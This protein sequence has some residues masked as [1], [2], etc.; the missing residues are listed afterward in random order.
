MWKKRNILIGLTL[1]LVGLAGIARGESPTTAPTTR[2]LTPS[3]E[4]ELSN[5]VKQLVD[6]TRDSK[7][8]AEA[9]DLLLTRPYPQ[10]V[11]AVKTLLQDTGNPS[12]QIAIAEGIVR[13]RGRNEYVEPLLEMLAGA[14]MAV[15]SPAGRALATYKDPTVMRKLIALAMDSGRDRSM[16]LP[17]IIALKRVLDKEVVDALMKLLDD[18]DAA[19]RDTAM[20]SLEY[21]TNLRGFH[22]PSQWKAWWEPLKNRDRHDWLA[23]LAE[24]VSRTKTALETENQKLGE[25]LRQSFTETYNGMASLPARDAFTAKLL[26]EPLVEARLTGLVLV[27]R[28]L[29]AA[30]GEPLS[31]DMGSQVRSLLA[32]TDASVREEAA[33]TMGGIGDTGSVQALMDRLKLEDSVAVQAALLSALGQLRD[34]KVLPEVLPRIASRYDAVSTAAAKALRRIAMKQPLAENPRQ[35]AVRA[36]VGRYQQA[37][38]ASASDTLVVREALLGAM[39]VL[40][41][42]QFLPAFQ[43]ACKDGN[44]NIRQMGATA[45]VELKDPTAVESL[46]PLLSDSDRNVRLAAVTGTA[47][48]GGETHLVSVLQRVDPAVEPEPSVREAAWNASLGIFPQC[49]DR[50]LVGVC[51]RLKERDDATVPYAQVL[52]VLV[53]RLKE[54]KSP[55][56]APRQRELALAFAVLRQPVEAA[57]QLAD[58]LKNPAVTGETASAVWVE[59]VEYLLAAEDLSVCRVLSEQKNEAD[60][61]RGI[62]KLLAHLVQGT[63][64]NYG[65]AMAMVDEARRVLTTR[66]SEPRRQAMADVHEK[67]A[68]KQAQT[69]KALVTQQVA[70]LTGAEESARAAAMTRL[71]ALGDRALAPLLDELRKELATEKPRA[72]AERAILACLKQLAPQWNG[73][74]LSATTADKLARLDEWTKLATSQPAK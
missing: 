11:E 13:H 48:L 47:A 5:S 62:E 63:D 39:S 74:N 30:A 69:D 67:C 28:R 8:K 35:E 65:A 68:A 9:A 66:L 33:V 16:R 6:R 7:T 34:T 64:D 45:I 72:D 49:S 14:D 43:A 3:E 31:A 20:E 53:D 17:A 55:D 56:L 29:E 44:A 36:L 46:L 51:N 18:R 71:T 1:V 37:A 10:A 42:K 12:A 60:F 70:I 24:S 22:E 40:Q 4:I 38:A 25:R 27:Q 73:Y 15:R 41:D 54:S 23:D 58:L 57:A 2:P 32:D 26:T 50:L 61:N 21:L 59:Y 19:V 52:K